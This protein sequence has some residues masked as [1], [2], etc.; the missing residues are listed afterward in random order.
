MSLLDL[1][2][3]LPPFWSE[4]VPDEEAPPEP[5]PT[6]THQEKDSDTETRPK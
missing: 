3:N 4:L 6:Q 2:T 5:T 1:L